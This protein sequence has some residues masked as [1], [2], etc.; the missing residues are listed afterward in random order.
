M[1]SAVRAAV[2]SWPTSLEV[3]PCVG[4][5]VDRAT[6]L[7]ALAGDQ[8]PDVDD[9]LALLAGDARPVVRVGRVGQVLV[10]LELVDAR[11]HQV[12]HPQP[13]LRSLEEVLDRHLL[14]PGDDVLDHGAGVEVLEVEDLLVAVG[15]GHFEEAVLLGLGVHPRDGALDHRRHGRLAAAAVLTEILFVQRQVGREVLREDVLRGFRVRALD[16]DLHVEAAGPQDRRVDHVLAVGRTDHDDVLEP[17]DAVDLTEQLRDDGVLDVAR[18]SRPAG[19]E[20]RVHLVEEDDDGSAFTR[21]LTGALEH[22]PDV[23]LGLADVLVEQLGAFDV[24]EVGAPLALAGLGDL[25][26][27]RVGDRLGDQR[28]SAARRAVEQDALRWLELVL[29]EQVLVQERQLDGVADL[30]D[31]VAKA[32]DV[33]IAD[34]R[35]LFE[36]EL[37]DLALRNALVGPAGARV[38]EHRVAGAQRLVEKR[39]G[40]HDHPLLVGVTDDESA[41]A[42]FEDLLQQDDVALPLELPHLHDVERLVEHDLLATVQRVELDGRRDGHAQLAPAREDVDRAVVVREQEVAVAGRRLCE[43]VDLLLERDDLLPRFLQG[44]HEPFV[45]VHD[46]GEVGLRLGDALLELANLAG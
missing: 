20:D 3:L 21:L 9:A 37:L 11:G 16:L 42:A 1:R 17:L 39:V 40:Q 6:A 36:D 43:P 44:R 14:R 12:L 13:L 19:T 33:E 10:L 35:N 15:V 34:V 22:Q 29:E 7:G 27:E 38:D 26:R 30:L 25:L 4:D 8:R 31:L 41:I 2:A 28:L 18:H 5:G 46:A 45:L 23:P 24:E 32:T